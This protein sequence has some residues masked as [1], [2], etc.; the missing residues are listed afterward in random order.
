MD[1]NAML[2]LLTNLSVERDAAKLGFLADDIDVVLKAFDDDH[3]TLYA[4]PRARPDHEKHLREALRELSAFCR[5]N[6]A[7]VRA[8]F[9]KR[10]WKQG[11][12]AA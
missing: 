6:E 5:A 2:T 4:T 1:Y 12:H 8:Q 10:Y 3:D 9:W 11:D 7:Q